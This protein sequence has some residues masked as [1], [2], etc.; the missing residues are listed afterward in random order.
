MNFNFSQTQQEL[1]ELVGYLAREHF[2][3][4]A[5]EAD[6]QGRV[7]LE[8]LKDLYENGLLGLTISKERGG[9][10]SGV[11]GGDP[12]LYLLAVEQ[13]ARV[14]LSTAHCLHIH[15]HACHLIDQVCTD[16]Q[17]ETLLTPVLERGALIAAVGSEPGR[18]A[19][20]I[21]N[22]DT[23]AQ[24]LR[25][26]V[27]LNGTKNYAT[28][29]S[30]AEYTLVFAAIKGQSCLEGHLGVAV[31]RGT[32]G[33]EIDETA[34]DPIGMRSAVSPTIV[35]ENCFVSDSLIVGAPGVYPAER[36][37][38]RHYLSLAAQY[39]GAMEG[40]FDSLTQYLPHRGTAGDQFTQLRLGEIRV[41][42]D[43]VR[44]LIYRAA[45]L[46]AQADLQQSELFSLVAK[47][48]A[49]QAAVVVMDKAA[50]IAGSSSL[51]G[52]GQFPRMMRDLRIHT[53][54]SNVDKTAAV[55]GKYHLGQSFDTTD[56][57]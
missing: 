38:A 8:N 13:T 3:P 17:R 5:A 37:Q 41:L 11:M 31:P 44:W 4:R 24:F 18:T 1:Y 20:G 46:W 34:W 52:N 54:H 36:W 2:A 42:I 49:T 56:R 45:W 35:L 23:T 39:L 33:L 57:L 9:L 22:M 51:I 53:L 40:L 15:L 50:Q 14:D 21:Y 10:G 7:P 6:A 29:A 25:D 47:H 32:P 16:A 27:A 43:S 28:L 12:L 48:Q 55:I 26:G 19:R 30:V